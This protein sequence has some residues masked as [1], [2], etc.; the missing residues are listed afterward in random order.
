MQRGHVALILETAQQARLLRRR[1]EQQAQRLVAMR[2]HHH[3]IKHVLAAVRRQH[4]HP[5]PRAMPHHARHRATQPDAI[6][7]GRD[8]PFHVFARPTVHRPPGMLGVQAQETVVVEKPQQ[9]R[10]GKLHHALRRRAPHRRAHR[11]QIKVP[12]ITTVSAPPH[13]VRQA[14]VLDGRI[15]LQRQHRLLVKAIHRHQHPDEARA[16]EISAL[17]EE[18]V[19]RRPAPL[20]AGVDILH[21]EA[22]VGAFHRRFQ[23]VE[24]ATKMRIR[25]AVKHHEPGVDRQRPPRPGF[26]RLDRV[27]VPAR[28]ILRAEAGDLI[29]RTMQEMSGAETGDAGADDSGAHGDK[30]KKGDAKKESVRGVAPRFRS[31]PQGAKKRSPR[32]RLRVLKGK[33]S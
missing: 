30:I 10:G 12:K 8:E 13:V 25:D 31:N 1:I 14:F 23:L 11:H 26:Y 3:T 4:R 7:E 28:V 17:R 20:Q 9:R 27:A 29:A 19:K 18:V 5:A 16:E 21:R 6:R 24:Q 33:P 15:V 22:H 2:R 32:N